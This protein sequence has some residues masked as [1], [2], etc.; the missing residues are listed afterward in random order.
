M[1]NSTK[2]IEKKSYQMDSWQ[3]RN[4]DSMNKAWGLGKDGSG[5]TRISGNSQAGPGPGTN[6]D[7][8]KY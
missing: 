7:Y 2:T 5:N 1:K 8:A 3:S 4:V 6:G